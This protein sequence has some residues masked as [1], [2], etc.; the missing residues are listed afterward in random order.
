VS[1]AAQ[2]SD[3]RALGVI[4]PKLMPP[5]VH[6]GMLRRA[7]LLQTLDEAR[8]APLTVIN[9]GVG[10]GK[11]TL[12]RSWCTERPEAVIWLTLDAA[13]DARGLV[14][15]ARA[16]RANCRPG[17]DSAEPHTT[18][19]GKRLDGGIERP[20]GGEFPLGAWAR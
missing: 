3:V 1:A 8:A 6:A 10:Y 13:D 2:P 15:G 14:P 4:E 17:T 18:R 11:T 20:P 19:G 5:R 16:G 12:A 9:A 7:R